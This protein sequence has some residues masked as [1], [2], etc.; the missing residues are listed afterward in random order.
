MAALKLAA[1]GLLLAPT[2]AAAAD[3]VARWAAPKQPL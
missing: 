2:A 3:S 1:A